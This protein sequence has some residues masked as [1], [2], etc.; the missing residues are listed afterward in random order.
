MAIP[1]VVDHDVNRP[2]FRFDDG[3]EGCDRVELRQAEQLYMRLPA[4][5]PFKFRCCLPGPSRS[6]D[7]VAG[8]QRGV[9]DS[10]AEATADARNKECLGVFHRTILEKSVPRSQ[11]QSYA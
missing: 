7:A 10:A 2:E 6:D 5:W 11:S 9:R 3:G 8:L 1:C 4:A